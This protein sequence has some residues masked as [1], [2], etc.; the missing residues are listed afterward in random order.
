MCS[1]AL[2]RKIEDRCCGL[3]IHKALCNSQLKTTSTLKFVQQTYNITQNIRPE[4]DWCAF[5]SPS[6]RSSHYYVMLLAIKL[7]SYPKATCLPRCNYPTEKLTC[8]CTELLLT[9]SVD[10]HLHPVSMVSVGSYC[11]PAIV[12]QRFA[13]SALRSEARVCILNIHRC[14]HYNAGYV[15]TCPI[16]NLHHHL[17]FGL[18]IQAPSSRYSAVILLFQA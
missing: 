15:F 4:S 9:S 18:M 14:S 12:L 13:L 11:T 7:L 10:K 6:L 3:E 17:S 1:V 5:S 8:T 16:L 2:Q